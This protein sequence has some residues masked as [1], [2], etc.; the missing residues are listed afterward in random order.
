M[1][2]SAKQSSLPRKPARSVAPNAFIRISSDGQVKATM[3]IDAQMQ[4]FIA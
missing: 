2:A 4:R 3:L 1:C